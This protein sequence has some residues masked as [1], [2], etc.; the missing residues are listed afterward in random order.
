MTLPPISNLGSLLASLLGY[1]KRWTRQYIEQVIARSNRRIASLSDRLE[2]I[3][4]GRT[5][6]DLEDLALNSGR[7]FNMAVLF[8]DICSFTKIPSSNYDEQTK[9]LALLGV[10]MT[11]MMN[12]VRDHDGTFEKNTGDGLMAYFGTETSSDIESVKSAVDAAVLMVYVAENLINPWLA[13]QGLPTV[14]FRIGID[15]GQVTIGR[16]GLKGTNSF[17][18]I[19]STANIANRL[20]EL[21]PDGGI[22]IGNEVY[23]HLPQSW[24]NTVTPLPP[25]TGFVYVLTGAAYPAWQLNYRLTGQPT[26]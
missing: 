20:M 26:S 8:L 12:I 21:I 9:V 14:R 4:Q 11:E 24:L 25:N 17:V 19:G 5:M 6:P 13:R 16:I 1:P 18:A 2:A 10:F 7:R 3:G 23:R 22:A 15:Y